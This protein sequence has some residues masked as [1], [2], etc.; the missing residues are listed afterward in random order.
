[1]SL[2]ILITWATT[3]SLSL[4][5]KFMNPPFFRLF[6]VILFLLE[7]NPGVSHNLHMTNLPSL[8]HKIPKC[9][10]PPPYFR[11][12][13]IKTNADIQRS[14]LD[15][16]NSKP[17]RFNLTVLTLI[18]L[19][20]KKHIQLWTPTVSALVRLYDLP[21]ASL[22]KYIKRPLP[23]F[24]VITYKQHIHENPVP[25]PKKIEILNESDTETSKIIAIDKPA[26][27]P[28]HGVQK[29]YYNTIH[30]ILAKQLSIP[31]DSLYPVHRL[32]RQTTGILIWALDTQVVA[33]LKDK[34]SWVKKKIY[35]A[36]INGRLPTKHVTCTDD[37]VYLYPTRQM[38]KEYKNAKT[39][40]TE[41]VYDPIKNESIVQAQLDTGFPHQIRIHL[42]NLRTPIVDDPLYGSHGKYREVKISKREVTTEYWSTILGRTS[43]IQ[44]KRL[45]KNDH[46]SCHVCGAARYNDSTEHAICL[47]AWKYS[48]IGVSEGKYHGEKHEFQTTQLPTWCPPFF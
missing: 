14:I 2:P 16:L 5:F 7:A 27:I 3:I 36:R 37:L 34:M 28:V 42:R 23:P 21:P 10:A 11:E 15:T 22:A 13:L 25:L 18:Q 6:N 44:H 4:Y 39:R 19:I 32:D 38:I 8:L 20:G 12:H 24:S 31:M 40:F 43:D 48:W 45:E 9:F 47:H 33:K 30:S 46:S 29:Y 41:M 35:L 26:G 17:Y 1:M